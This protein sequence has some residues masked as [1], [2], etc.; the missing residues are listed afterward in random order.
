MKQWVLIRILIL[1][2]NLWIFICELFLVHFQLQ[3]RPFL[4]KE[5]S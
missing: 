3:L 4:V 2:N 1:Y 5:S